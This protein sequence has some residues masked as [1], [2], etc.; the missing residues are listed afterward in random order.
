MEGSRVSDETIAEPKRRDILFIATGAM[1]AVAAGAAVWPLLEQMNPDAST[2]ALA[3]AENTPLAGLPDPE[4]DSKRVKKPE[5][6]VVIG[7]CTHLGCIPLGHEGDFDGWF[8][9]CH[10]STYDTSGRIRS[11]PAPSN[12][13]VPNYAFL[14]DT[15]IKI[16]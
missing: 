11:G 6:L 12:L 16:G 14:T 7:V 3:S 1:A 9:P 13:E 10:G 5:W 2:L 15:K 8:C 4:A